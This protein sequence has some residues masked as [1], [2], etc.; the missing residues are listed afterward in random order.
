MRTI[1]T[2]LS[3]IISA[4][5]KYLCTQSESVTKQQHS[6]G[7]YTATA[8]TGTCVILAASQRSHKHSP[9]A[10]YFVSSFLVK[11]IAM[12]KLTVIVATKRKSPVFNT[13]HNC[14][15]VTAR[16]REDAS[17][18]HPADILRRISSFVAATA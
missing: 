1:K 6:T 17:I 5:G 10:F 2:Q 15:V 8:C 11:Q 3:M 12:A 16:Q 14:V 7:I 9:Q 4:T 13:G 18:T